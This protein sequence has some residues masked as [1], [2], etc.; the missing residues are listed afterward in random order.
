MKIIDIITHQLSCNVETPF[1]SSRGW[2]YKTKG[3][4]VVEIVTDEGII[5]WGDCYGPAAVSKSV[6]D[7]LLKPSIIGLDPFDVEVI[8]ELLYNKVKDYGLTGMTISGISGVDIALWDIMGKA[9]KQPVYRLLGGSRKKIRAYAGGV[10]MGF[11]PPPALLE[12]AQSFVDK[13][14]TAIKL[15]MGDT[16]ENDLA[17]VRAVRKGLGDK[18]D[19]AVDINTRYNFLDLQRALPGYEECRVFW[20]EEPFAPDAIADY[21]HFN[22]RTHVPLAGGEN[23]FLR[24]QARELLERKAVDVIQ[25]DPAKAGGITETKKIADLAAAFRRAFAPHVGMSAIDSAACVHLLCA[26]SN[27]LIYEADGAAFNPFRDDLC[28]DY[29]KIVDGYIEPNEKPGLGFE[30][31]ESLF[32]K[33]P[34]IAGPCYV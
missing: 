31:D 20:V 13:G 32:E 4:L 26:A 8:W 25:P 18:I 23:H 3:A 27:A 29:P 16:V 12:E 1:T 7:T 21:A 6:V 19:I 14:F 5:G 30:V 17:R 28:A 33:W 11:K 24:Y 15:R 10:C 2:W 34:G 9:L 22:A